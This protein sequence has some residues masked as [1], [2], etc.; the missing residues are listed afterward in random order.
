V[1]LLVDTCIW[2]LALRRRESSPLNPLEQQ[3]VAELREAIQDRRVAMVGP[4]RQE[5]LSGIRDPAQFAR[6]EALLDPFRDQLIVSSDY[7]DAARLFNVCRAHGVEC[8]PVDT[9][10]LAVAIR[11]RLQVLTRDKGLARCVELLKAEGLW[12]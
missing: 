11:L 7:I 2:S 10:L 9:L 4:I 3:A 6:I 1:K 12:S 5:I 8:G